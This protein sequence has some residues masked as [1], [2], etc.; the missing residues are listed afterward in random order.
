MYK[1]NQFV[2]GSQ[3]PNYIDTN[4]NDNIYPDSYHLFKRYGTSNIFIPESCKLSNNK[5]KITE[6]DDYNKNKFIASIVF[7]QKNDIIKYIDY[8]TEETINNSI[9]QIISLRTYFH[10]CVNHKIHLE[11]LIILLNKLQ[12][13]ADDL[14]KYMNE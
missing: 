7:L 8:Q 1:Y 14:N 2:I 3:K 13:M 5:V 6:D 9:K 11:I 12:S 10:Y 4:Y